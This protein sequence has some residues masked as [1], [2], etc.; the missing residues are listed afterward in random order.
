M[1]RLGPTEEQLKPF[2]LTSVQFR[3][4]TMIAA[5]AHFG[6][7]FAGESTEVWNELERRGLVKRR[8]LNGVQLTEQGDAFLRSIHELLGP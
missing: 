1:T 6:D 4:L 2:N 8:P 5:G 3:L 7:G